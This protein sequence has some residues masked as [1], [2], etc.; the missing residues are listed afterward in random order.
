MD[1]ATVT[2]FCNPPAGFRGKVHFMIG[3]NDERTGRT[4]TTGEDEEGR[5]R[6]LLNFV[7]K[8]ILNPKSWITSTVRSSSWRLSVRLSNARMTMTS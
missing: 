5:M 8:S 1:T 3:I 7:W 2:V 6:L 4:R